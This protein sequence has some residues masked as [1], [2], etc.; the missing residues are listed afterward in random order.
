LDDIAA[1]F[2]QHIKNK[3]YAIAIIGNKNKLDMDFLKG[4]GTFKEV[5]DME[6]FGY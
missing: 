5:N 4:L 1:Y 2:D 3:K 6:I